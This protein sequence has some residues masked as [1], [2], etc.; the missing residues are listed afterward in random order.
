MAVFDRNKPYNALPELPPS[1]SVKDTDVLT[2]WGLASRALAELNKNILR[3]PNPT[4]WQTG[5]RFFTLLIR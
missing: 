2:K 3:I 4:G 1:G 5:A